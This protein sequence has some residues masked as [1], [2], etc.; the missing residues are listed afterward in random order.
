MLG[1]SQYRQF[2]LWVVASFLIGR[3]KKGN[4]LLIGSPF[5]ILWSQYFISW[6]VFNSLELWETMYECLKYVM[7]VD[8]K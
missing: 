4:S 3:K 6:F 8:I 2:W 1:Q 7:D 5:K